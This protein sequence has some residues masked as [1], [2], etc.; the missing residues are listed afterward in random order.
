MK[1][2]VKLLIFR[3]SNKSNLTESEVIVPREDILFIDND[4]REVFV[5]SIKSGKVTNYKLQGDK[6]LFFLEDQLDIPVVEH[7]NWKASSK[8]EEK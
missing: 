7:D 4:K 3:N 5:R 8:E 2:F 6:G 1:Q